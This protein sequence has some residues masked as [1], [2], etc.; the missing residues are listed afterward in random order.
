MPAASRDQKVQRREEVFISYSRRDKE[1]VR[2]LDE[3]LK[4]REREAWVDWEGIPPGD[5]WEKTIY[6]A[7]EA[8]HTFIFVLTPDSIASEVCG[9]EIAHAAA[10]NKRLVPIVHR[11][12]AA[13]RVPKSL[14]EL[15]WI[16]CRDSDDFQKA[17]DTLVSAL[18]TDLEW[19]HAHTDLLTQAIKWEANSK[20]RSLVLRGEALKAAEQ[21]LAQ[22]GAQKERQPT[23]LQTEYIIAS[24]KAAA[25]RQR[26]TLGAVSFGF[27]VAVVLAVLALFARKEAITQ[28]DIAVQQQKISHSREL[29]A[30]ADTQLSIDPELSILLA[31]EAARASPTAQAEAALRQALLKSHVYRALDT[32]HDVRIREVSFSPDGNFVVCASQDHA[33]RIWDVRTDKLIAEIR[34]VD[35]LKPTRFS[36]DGTMLLLISRAHTARLCETSSGKIIDEFRTSDP[37]VQVGAAVFGQDGIVLASATGSIVEV[38]QQRPNRRLAELRGHTKNVNKVTLSPDGRFAV[39]EA[40]GENARLWETTTGQCIATW[41]GWGAYFSADSKLLV[42]GGSRNTPVVHDVAT[43]QVISELRGDNGGI[44]DFA[45]R[46]DHKLVAT[47]H[48]MGMARVWDAATGQM[49]LEVRGAPGPACLQVAFS[50]NGQFLLTSD[51]DDAMRVWLLNTGDLVAVLRAPGN[52]EPRAAFSADSHFIVGGGSQIG[53]IWAVPKLIE[54]RGHTD[55]LWQAAFSPDSKFLVTAARDPVPRVWDAATGK[56]LSELHGHTGAVWT[57]VFSPNG[58]R[59]L[60]GSADHTA[61]IWDAATGRSL[62]EL[63]DHTSDVRNATFSPDGRLALTTGGSTARLWD[64]AT[65]NPLREVRGGGK[66][67]TCARFSPDGKLVATGGDDA[68]ARIWETAT[69]NCTAE[70][71]GHEKTVNGVAFSLNGK[72]LVTDS[73]DTTARIWDVASGK[74]ISVLRGHKDLVNRF[75][76][77]F[78][79]DSKLVLRIP[80]YSE[81]IIFDPVR[82]EQLLVFR[83]HAS[84]ITGGSFSPDGRFVLTADDSGRA[85]MWETLTGNQVMELHGFKRGIHAPAFSPDGKTIVTAGWD[86]ARQPPIYS[87][88][89][90]RSSDVCCP[91]DELL[92]LASQRVTR[93][94]TAAERINYLHEPAGQSRSGKL[95]VNAQAQRDVTQ[96]P[97]PKAQPEMVQKLAPSPAAASADITLVEKPIQAITKQSQQ[98]NEPNKQIGYEKDGDHAAPFNAIESKLPVTNEPEPDINQVPAITEQSQ[99]ENGPSKQIASSETINEPSSLPPQGGPWLFP[100]SSSRYLSATELSSLSSDDLWRARNEIFARKGYKFSSPR[101]IA[102]AHTLGNYYHGVDD[103]QDR[104]FNSMNQYEKANVKL[105]QSKMHQ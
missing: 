4:R 75:V 19:V 54:L 23:T 69:G 53:R 13:D 88:A 63:R 65:G 16:F 42:H 64:A 71:R 1:F 66:V 85:I 2:R 102:F 67:V 90:L 31:V 52:R 33:A 46:A 41:D 5:K 91:L 51:A 25:K 12:V 24:R 17:T 43:G 6:G 30:T 15:N 39:T 103:N 68:T 80:H 100:D 11:D 83:G 58:G 93:S 21:W 28:R 96:Q 29:A 97:Q 74:T 36:P 38:W 50:P 62:F 20:S 60:T 59:I 86:P 94:L 89:Q 27:V 7:I 26:L 92:K 48:F 10:N 61:R 22:A 70:L 40:K 104:V 87:S 32:G 55:I 73:E 49:I 84:E 34:D 95:E 77:V 44:K 3:E 79:P 101:G 82:G 81:P 14:G 45:F 76:S 99:Q 78:S 98:E 8:T 105:I 57:A 9:K 35:E 56:Q 18:D 72:M 47:A 37:K